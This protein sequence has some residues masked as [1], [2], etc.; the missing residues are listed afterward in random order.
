MIFETNYFT[1]ASLETLL[2]FRLVDISVLLI[3][4]GYKEIKILTFFIKEGEIKI[5][6]FF[7]KE[8]LIFT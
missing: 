7:I 5:F 4:S 6:T 2:I 8:G 3:N 1:K